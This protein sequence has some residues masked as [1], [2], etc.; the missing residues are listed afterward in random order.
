MIPQY[1]KFNRLFKSIENVDTSNRL[2]S[3]EDY[4]QYKRLKRDRM[5][6]DSVAVEKFRNEILSSKLDLLEK[7]IV[8]LEQKQHNTIQNFL[9]SLGVRDQLSQQ[10]L[11]LVSNGKDI[12]VEL[13]DH[14]HER[15]T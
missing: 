10:I 7:K 15:K 6:K 2:V 5:C 9:H 8:K 1:F 13:I 12:P 14:L 3:Y 11:S 4:I